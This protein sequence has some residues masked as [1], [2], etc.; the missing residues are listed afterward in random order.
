MNIR[1]INANEVHALLACVIQLSE[2]HN[3]VSVHFKGSFPSRPYEQTL[4][5]F[6]ENLENGTSRIAVVEDAGK[7]VGFC[8]VDIYG[9]NGKPDHLV[10]LPECRGRGM[11]K[12]LMDRAMT[13]FHQ[14]E[15]A[16]IEV[17]VIDGNDAI[18]LYE[19]YGF[20]MNA[21]ILWHCAE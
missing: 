11:G 8:K 9:K 2:H 3:Q 5:A 20:R 4:A 7:I 16:R 21:H 19:K 6:S 12:Q 14:N 18:H 13:T 17:K 1:E 15:V 10:V